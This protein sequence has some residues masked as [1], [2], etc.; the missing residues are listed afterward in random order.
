[1]GY[2]ELAGG[3][4]KGVYPLEAEIPSTEFYDGLLVPVLAGTTIPPPFGIENIRQS[5]ITDA[6]NTGSAISLF[7]IHNSMAK[8]IALNDLKT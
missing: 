1:M 7:H 2:I 8:M 6:V 5:G 4:F 3:I